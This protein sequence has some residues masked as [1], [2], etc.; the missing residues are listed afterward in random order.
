MPYG[1]SILNPFK[2]SLTKGRLGGSVPTSAQVM[3]AQSVGSSPASGSVPT[4]R[5]LE[6]LRILCLP[7][8]LPLTHSPSVCLSVSLSKNKH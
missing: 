2:I 7:L 6:L 5:S 4:A 1:C 3:I 8:S